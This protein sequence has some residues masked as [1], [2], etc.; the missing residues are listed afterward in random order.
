MALRVSSSLGLLHM[1]YFVCVSCRCMCAFLLG[2]FLEIGL[3][4]PRAG[5]CI[6]FLGTVGLF[7]EVVVIVHILTR[8]GEG[9]RCSVSLS[10]L[11]IFSLSGFSLLEDVKWCL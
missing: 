8:K 7:C 4:G 2:M 5:T 9:P 11:G 6:A 10:A 3:L 1:Q